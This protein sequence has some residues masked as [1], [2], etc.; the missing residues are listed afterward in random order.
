MFSES[1]SGIHEQCSFEFDYF[2][3][4]QYILIALWNEYNYYDQIGL[5]QL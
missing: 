4:S 5:H 2:S 1:I 3:K